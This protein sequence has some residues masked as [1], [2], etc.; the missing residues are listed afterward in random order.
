MPRPLIPQKSGCCL[1]FKRDKILT[2]RGTIFTPEFTR[3]SGVS[4]PYPASAAARFIDSIKEAVSVRNHPTLRTTARLIDWNLEV[5]RDCFDCLG[6]VIR[7]SIVAVNPAS[8]P[9]IQMEFIGLC[10]GSLCFNF[11]SLVCLV[12]KKLKILVKKI[13]YSKLIIHSEF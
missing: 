2:D 11:G 5:I 12:A 4:P 3:V 1:R 6:A 13:F 8:G 7:T 9:S 10:R